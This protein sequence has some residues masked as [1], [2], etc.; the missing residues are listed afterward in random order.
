MT[1]NIQKIIGVF[2]I[3]IGVIPFLGITLGIFT[4]IIYAATIISGI[5]VLVAGLK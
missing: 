4:Q 3:I 1:W 5:I 2:L